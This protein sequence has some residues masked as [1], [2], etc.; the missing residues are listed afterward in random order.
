MRLPK[1]T[2]LATRLTAASVIA[3]G[4]IATG[5]GVASAATPTTVS[6]TGA[7][8]ASV[9]TPPAH[10]TER[11]TE[12]ATF[13]AK[14]HVTKT[15][16]KTHTVVSGDTLSGIAAQAHTP[17]GW[18]AIASANHIANPNLI[19]PGQKLV[20]PTSGKT[21]AAP[22]TQAAQPS[23]ATHSAPSA[24]SAHATVAQPASYVA[25]TSNA[26]NLDGWIAQAQAVLAAHGDHVP[27]AAAIKARAMTESSGNPLAQNHWDGNQALYG[28]TYGLMQFI[29]PTFNQWALP[30]HTDIMNPVDSII[31]SV[32]YANHQY[33][34]FENI[35]YT[36]SGY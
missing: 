35:A 14:A 32:R 8:R 27:A 2:G 5:A 19:F 34:A 30:G 21:T 33:G 17:G 12:H 4:L 20:L 16:T 13:A 7:A 36:K 26:N 3:G 1:H 10:T 28:G 6:H 31:A 9:V 29:Q 24:H 18:T 22:A 15:G 23:A 11:T 25:V